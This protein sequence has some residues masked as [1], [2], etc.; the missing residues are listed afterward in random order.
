METGPPTIFQPLP[1]LVHTIGDTE[2][3]Y[4]MATVIVHAI[5]AG[6]KPWNPLTLQP[7]AATTDIWVNNMETPKLAYLDPLVPAYTTLRF[8]N[9]HAQ[10]TTATTVDQRLA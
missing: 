5:L 2:D 8:T 10:L 3:C 6:Q 9:R 4:T 7:M 1:T